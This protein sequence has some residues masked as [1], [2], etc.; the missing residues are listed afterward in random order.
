MYGQLSSDARSQILFLR[1]NYIKGVNNI[2]PDLHS[3]ILPGL[4]KTCVRAC[5][6][7]CVHACGCVYAC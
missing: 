5:M 7:E 1:L 3:G 2:A 6:R 4:G